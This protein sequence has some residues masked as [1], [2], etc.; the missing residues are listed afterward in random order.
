LAAS[1]QQ[2]LKRRLA[3]ITAAFHNQTARFSAW[4]LF[5]SRE[6]NSRLFEIPRVLVR[7]DYV[8]RLYQRH[9]REN[10]PFSIHLDVALIGC[11]TRGAVIDFIAV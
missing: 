1:G 3:P 8:A 6:Q 11:S 7:F 2:S 9:D 4:R 10:L 5:V